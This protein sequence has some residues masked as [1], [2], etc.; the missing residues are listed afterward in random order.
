[1]DLRHAMM[2]LAEQAGPR[3]YTFA[4]RV[5]PQG[6]TPDLKK[7][8]M[9]PAVDVPDAEGMGYLAAASPAAVAIANKTARSAGAVGGRA[10]V[11][12]FVE[13]FV[14]PETKILDYGSGPK[15]IH[16]NALREKGFDVTAHDFGANVVEGIH[17]P[18]AL[19]RQYG[20]VYASNVLNVQSDPQMLRETLQEIANAVQ[21]GGSATLN[22]PISPRKFNELSAPMVEQEL[23]KLFSKVERIG[24]TRA[25]PVYRVAK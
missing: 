18:K 15:A 24:G 7:I 17:D 2:G 5:I 19:T 6:E 13:E 3:G 14:T 8:M 1:M 22:L 20:H 16:A 9:Q 4:G 21:K 11:P 25:A 10:T 23:A 12:R